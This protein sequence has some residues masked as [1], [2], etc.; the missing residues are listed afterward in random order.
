M[1]KVSIIIP[2][3]NSEKYLHNCIKS[4]INQTYKNFEVL[5]IDDGST[6]QSGAICDFYSRKY[7]FIKSFHFSNKGVSFARNIGINESDGDYVSFV[8]SDDTIDTLFLSKMV[9]GTNNGYFDIV[10]C[11]YKTIS[12]EGQCEKSYEDAYEYSDY[13]QV[14]PIKHL[15][16]PE[17]TVSN[18][19]W[20][21]LFKR[22]LLQN[23][24]FDVKYRIGEDIKFI[25]ECIRNSHNF[26]SIGGDYYNYLLRKESVTK[27]ATSDR[28]FDDFYLN[29]W[30][31]ELG[32]EDL[33]LTKAIYIRDA[34]RCITIYY[35]FLKS[36][37]EKEKMIYI[38]KR[39]KNNPYHHRLKGKNKLLSFLILYSP[40][41]LRLYS[42]CHKNN[43]N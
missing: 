4:I 10:Q 7:S 27:A 12:E 21:K 17:K 34:G 9:E 31:L 15:F 28:F 40:W 24:R 25:V 11:G 16:E 6:D 29:D 32:Y 42:K 8:D 22:E 39:L 26:K 35:S 20:S 37:I 3:F 30:L 41:I 18:S 14:D 38:R 2:V 13:N 33:D 19:V 1:I 43:I 23:I 36:N 5:L